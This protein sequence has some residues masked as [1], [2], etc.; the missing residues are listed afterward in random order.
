MIKQYAKHPG[1]TIPEPFIW[2]AYIGLA[3]G[4]AYMQTGGEVSSSFLFR[5]VWEGIDDLESVYFA[6][7]MIFLCRNADKIDV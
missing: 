5:C 2:H 6:V 4:L 3:D 7:L 1:E